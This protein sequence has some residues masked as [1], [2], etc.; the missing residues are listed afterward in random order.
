VPIAIS[1]EQRALQ[2]SIREWAARAGTLALVRALEPGSTTD[3]P[4]S[5]AGSPASPAGLPGTPAGVAHEKT[6]WA[7]HWAALADPAVAG[8]IGAVVAGGLAGSLMDLRAA[9]AELAGAGDTHQAAVRKLVGVAH[10]QSVAETALVL[11]GADAAASDG[12]AG[13]AV[14]AFLLSRCLSIAGGT[15][16]ILLSMVAERALGLLRDEAR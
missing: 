14:Y 10:R 5:Q 2:A 15:S 16:Q 13:D 8:Q 4:A 7:E 9:L 1:A 6:P 3:A 11:S 12:P